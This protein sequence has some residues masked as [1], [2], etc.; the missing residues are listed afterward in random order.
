MAS[1]YAALRR[2]SRPGIVLV[3]PAFSQVVVN[4]SYQHYYKPADQR[5]QRSSSTRSHVHQ[6]RR[7][8]TFSAA[9]GG[10]VERMEAGGH[11][12]IKGPLNPVLVLN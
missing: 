5:N 3:S 8:S 11:T 9:V 4:I 7:I 10:L 2:I 6:T 12:C 1:G